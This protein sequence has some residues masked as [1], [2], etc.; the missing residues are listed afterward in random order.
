MYLQRQGAPHSESFAAGGW[1]E[2]G[3][4]RTR[5][6]PRQ[7]LG[8]EGVVVGQRLASNSGV[9]GRLARGGQVRELSG[10]L[11]VLLTGLV[12]DGT[13]GKNAGK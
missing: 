3:Y 11:L 5:V 13:C 4:Q 2:A 1:A 8:E 9:G 12:G 7:E 10:R 6:V